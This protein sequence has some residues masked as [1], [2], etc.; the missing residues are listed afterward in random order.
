MTLQSRRSSPLAGLLGLLGVVAAL[1]AGLL[2]SPGQNLTN[3]DD[4]ADATVAALEG[5]SGQ[6]AITR[7]VSERTVAQGGLGEQVVQR[8]VA[9]GVAAAL[10]EPGTADALRATARQV[11]GQV[12]AR[13]PSDEIVIDLDEIREPIV[14][15]V[16]GIS[17]VAARLV[18]AE[19]G[20]VQ[21]ADGEGVAAVGRVAWWA[22]RSGLLLGL[23]IGAIFGLLTA[24]GAE[25]V[26]GGFGLGNR[27]TTYSSTI[28]MPQFFAVILILS[29]LGILI[30]VAFFLIGKKWAGWQS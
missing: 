1:L 10:A 15:G 9:A 21:I 22:G 2:V 27:L 20:S 23:M 18:P 19:L 13:D 14:E 29:T 28:Q 8:A 11:H 7:I 30:Y 12:V 24:V 17:P 16:A 3:A 5:E 25:M 26:G 6:E 4:F